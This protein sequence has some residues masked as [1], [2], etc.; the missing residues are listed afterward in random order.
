MPFAIYRQ[1]TP[2]E[3]KVKVVRRGRINSRVV[4]PN[5]DRVLVQSDLLSA[6]LGPDNPGPH[7]PGRDDP[8]EVPPND[9][10]V[11]LT[12]LRRLY[13][14]L[15]AVNGDRQ[16]KFIAIWNRL[17]NRNG[18]Q[19][20]LFLNELFKRSC[21]QMQ[22]YDNA[23]EHFYGVRPPREENAIH[24]ANQLV[25][26]L[27]LNGADALELDGVFPFEYLDYEIS[28]IRTTTSCWENGRAATNSGAGGMDLLLVTKTNPPQPVVAE[29]KARTETV[30]AT[31]ALIQTLT[32]A[33]ELL[34]K[35]QMLRLQTHFPELGA[36]NSETPQLGLLVIL[37]GPIT[38]P[39]HLI[40]LRYAIA[41]AGDLLQYPEIARSI[42][43][44]EFA[45][46]NLN[47][48]NATLTILLGDQ[49]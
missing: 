11:P 41:L 9:R 4:L 37:E 12:P 47:G 13:Q 35:S 27:V 3:M 14:E 44:I 6:D 26:F 23:G 7:D 32:Y 10:V 48:E 19:R 46:G 22:M 28:P 5:G 21:Q 18:P 2:E 36:V 40:D 38:E 39:E 24:F 43:R 20:G 49:P 15:R 33:A 31:F 25:E 30:G 8:A 17:E 45:E 29:I 34:T 16:Q 42:S 1:G